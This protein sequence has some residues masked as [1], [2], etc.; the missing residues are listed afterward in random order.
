MIKAI[1]LKVK[2]HK[3]EETLMGMIAIIIVKY[4]KCSGESNSCPVKTEK[5][6]ESHILLKRRI[7]KTRYVKKCR[8]I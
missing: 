7:Y 2:H 1:I 8:Y 5:H 6:L 3:N 4:N